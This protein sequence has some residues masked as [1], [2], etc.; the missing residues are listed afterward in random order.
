VATLAIALLLASGC[1]RAA[2]APAAGGGRAA[3][4][5]SAPATDTAGAAAQQPA[6]GGMRLP[7]GL[8]SRG[9]VEGGTAVAECKARAKVGETVTIVGRIGGSRAPF[10]ASRAL[11]TI[12]DPALKPC[13]EMGEEDHCATPWDYC[14]EPR[15]SLTRNLATIEVAGPD[16]KV[17]PF[18]VRGADGLNPLATVEVTGTVTEANDKGLFVVRATRVRVP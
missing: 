1:D 16:G 17:L 9:P 3:S 8:V 12:V 11:F 2:P 6:P 5:T 4:T 7:D 13:S 10:V 14:C 18:S 15:E